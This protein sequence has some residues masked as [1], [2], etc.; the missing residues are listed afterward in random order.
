MNKQQVILVTP[1]DEAIGSMEK[2]E[3][4]E[5]GKLHR[6]FSVFIFNKKG[7]M[8][9]QQRALNKYHSAGL[10]SNACC[11]HPLPGEDT[12]KAAIRRLKEEMGFT[13]PLKKIFDFIYEASF[14]NGLT[15]NEF[16][17]VFSGEYDG[18][19]NINPQEVAGYCYKTMEEMKK[20]LQANP[21]NY[22]AWFHIAIPKIEKWWHGEYA[23]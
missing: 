6:A 13:T 18:E 11:S 12:E 4:H 23:R 2:I 17:H 19:I 16:D 8:L 14:D 1:L 3:A 7:E 21:E 20:S 22:T 10:W 5:K 15:E 9:L